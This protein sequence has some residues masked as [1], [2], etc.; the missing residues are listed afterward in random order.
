M[1]DAFASQYG[2]ERALQQESARL[3]PTQANQAYID[4]AALGNVGAMRDQKSQA[5]ID[6]EVNRYNYNSNLKRNNVKDYIAAINGNYGSSSTGTTQINEAQEAAW[7]R[8]LLSIGK[9]AAEGG[10]AGGW[11][12]AIAG[13]AVGAGQEFLKS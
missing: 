7:K 1:G 3:A 12:G 2:N 10:A 4:A 8:Y 6:E 9:G 11:P 13:G 5:Q